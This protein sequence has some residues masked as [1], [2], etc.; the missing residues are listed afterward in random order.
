MREPDWTNARCRTWPPEDFFLEQIPAEVAEQCCDPC[1]IRIACFEWADR[2][3]ELGFWGGTTEK[4][5]E[6]MT[7]GV[8]RTKCPVCAAPAPFRLADEQVCGFC[9]MSWPIKPEKTPGRT[10]SVA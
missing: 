10:A 9:G 1:P 3:G 5:R 6:A 7:S 4:Q 2:R 8:R